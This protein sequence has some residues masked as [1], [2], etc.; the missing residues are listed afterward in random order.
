MTN[1]EMNKVHPDQDNPH[2]WASELTESE[3]EEISRIFKLQA[4]TGDLSG[5][6]APA[7]PAF[8]GEFP[9]SQSQI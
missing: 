6:Q 4:E 9:T 7:R 5:F 3:L 1:P 8:R 2:K